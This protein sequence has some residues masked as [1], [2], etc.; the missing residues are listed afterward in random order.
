MK[1]L[2][3]Q[4]CVRGT[5]KHHERLVALGHE[6]WDRIRVVAFTRQPRLNVSARL[7]L[8]VVLD[9]EHR[10]VFSGQAIPQVAEVV[11]HPNRVFLER[12]TA[13]QLLYII[14]TTVAI[15]LKVW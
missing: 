9:V 1:A 3:E 15:S 10:A 12:V 13:R 5:L 14:T 4:R 6:T 7:A 8:W 2:I 11:G